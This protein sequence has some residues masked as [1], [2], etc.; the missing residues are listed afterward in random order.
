MILV[1]FFLLF[2]MYFL[3][4]LYFDTVFVCLGF[5]YIQFIKFLLVLKK[6]YLNRLTEH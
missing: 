5:I 4:Y 1:L 3:S 6:N 2:F